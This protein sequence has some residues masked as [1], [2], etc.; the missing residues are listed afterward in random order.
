MI[1]LG[2]AH[3]IMAAG[4]SWQS[5]VSVQL[6]ADASWLLLRSVYI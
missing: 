4:S 1:G 3:A 5:A 2:P 6:P